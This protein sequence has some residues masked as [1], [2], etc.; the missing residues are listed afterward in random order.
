MI[1]YDL[2][3][4]IALQDNAYHV[5]VEHIGDGGKLFSVVS[6]YAQ[7]L[8]EKG[9]C[10]P[11]DTLSFIVPFLIENEIVEEDI[12]KISFRAQ[13]VPGIKALF[14][15]LMENKNPIWV[16]ST[17]YEQ[18]AFAVAARAMIDRRRVFC[19]K[20]P[21]NEIR[22]KIEKFEIPIFI[23]D[24]RKEAVKL[25]SEIGT[26]SGDGKIVDLFDIFYS[27]I[28]K[29]SFGEAI[30]GIEPVG[31]EK[32]VLALKEALRVDLCLPPTAIDSY[33]DQAFIVVDG[34]VDAKMADMVNSFGG[35]ALGW[36]ASKECLLNCTCAV[37]ATDARAV[38]PVL[39]A[40]RDGGRD[41]VQEF[42]ETAVVV[43]S[44]HYSWIGDNSKKYVREEILP[45][46]QKFRSRLQGEVG[47]KLV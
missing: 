45:V 15:E 8:S 38:K 18:H 27:E 37:A 12:R 17:S 33:L 11:G 25:F 13:L 32:K 47:G 36:N 14:S 30:S 22:N 1:I 6:R 44:V 5:C 23:S 2:E 21:L 42:L 39:Q 41:A 10:E 19:T 35:I 3:G 29:N 9:R 43:N 24:F 28:S 16:I 40:W 4:P 20:F 7:I 46:H 26:D 34:L 31:G